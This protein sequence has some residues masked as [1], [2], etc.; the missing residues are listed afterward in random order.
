MTGRLAPA[1]SEVKLIAAR[2]VLI[3]DDDR[4]VA[5]YVASVVAEAGYEPVVAT[6]GAQAL[7]L[8]RLERPQLLITDLM[9]P[10]MSGA[11]LITAL[12]AQAEA[13]GQS[14]PPSIVMTSA[15]LHVAQ[16]AG[17]DAILCK[18]FD[19][20]DLERLL[21]RFLEDLPGKAVGRPH[22]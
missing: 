11:A 22:G 6:R 14:A 8:A 16:T 12:H 2:V 21:Q 3:V 1:L 10:F 18:P 7:D 20:D 13:E 19:L 17:A 9:L 5:D 4:T 15:S